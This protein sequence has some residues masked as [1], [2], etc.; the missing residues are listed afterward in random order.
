MP[1]SVT[2]RYQEQNNR[3]CKRTKKGQ[4]YITN[5]PAGDIRFPLVPCK[6]RTLLTV[7]WNVTNE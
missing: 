1:D 3:G 5:K 4:N 2:N 7:D 6:Q